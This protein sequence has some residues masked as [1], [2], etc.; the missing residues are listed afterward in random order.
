[1]IKLQHNRS[2]YSVD[3]Q[4]CSKFD[5]RYYYKYYCMLTLQYYS[6]AFRNR[7]V[8][9]NNK[10]Y[11]F[12]Y[13]ISTRKDYI[14]FIRHSLKF[15]AVDLRQDLDPY[16]HC[17]YEKHTRTRTTVRS[18]DVLQISFTLQIIRIR[19]FFCDL[20]RALP[21]LLLSD[22]ANSYR[23]NLLIVPLTHYCRKIF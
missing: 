16:R 1:M 14:R 20:Q 6:F 12:A 7:S 4:V 13:T 11:C 8:V 21:K 2:F 9:K 23:L 19:T 22:G 15:A 17:F 5:A 18:V 3:C 10:I